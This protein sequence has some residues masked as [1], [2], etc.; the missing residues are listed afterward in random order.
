MS[1]RSYNNRSGPAH[2][3]K[4]S[5]ESDSN[6]KDVHESK[7]TEKESTPPVKKELESVPENKKETGRVSRQDKKTAVDTKDQSN[8]DKKSSVPPV[9]ALQT[10]SEPNPAKNSGSLSNN[11]KGEQRH[12]STSSSN[13]DG[14]PKVDENSNHKKSSGSGRLTN[15]NVPHEVSIND[16][17]IVKKSVVSVEE[18]TRNQELGLPQRK[19]R[20]NREVKRAEVI[21]NGDLQVVNGH[22]EE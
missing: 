3:A 14:S 21:V 2:H 18:V 12:N 9:S 17:P 16:A 4:S 13:G 20:K 7:Q 19:P 10:D 5:S 11:N 22:L 15:G 1:S 6:T 8:V